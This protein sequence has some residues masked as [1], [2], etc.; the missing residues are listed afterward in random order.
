MACYKNVGLPSHHPSVHN[1]AS[2]SLWYVHLLDL[3]LVVGEGVGAG[4]C[5]KYLL[6]HLEGTWLKIIII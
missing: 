3:T 5:M 6:K 1:L 2:V 4:A